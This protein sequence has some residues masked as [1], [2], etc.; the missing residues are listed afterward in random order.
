MSLFESYSVEDI[1]NDILSKITEM[2]T[3]EGSFANTLISP[4]SYKI[5]EMLQ[6]LNAVVTIA[7][8]DETS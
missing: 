3:R 2:D 6:S 1:K 7:F 5:W 4:V 8:V